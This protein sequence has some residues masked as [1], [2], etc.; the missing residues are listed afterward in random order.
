MESVLVSLIAILHA[1]S[2]NAETAPIF[3]EEIVLGNSLFRDQ[4]R[5]NYFEYFFLVYFTY[6]FLRNYSFN[7]ILWQL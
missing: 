1:S 6:L 2:L 4:G 3:F 5:K 7:F